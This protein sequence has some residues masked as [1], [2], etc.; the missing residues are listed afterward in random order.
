MDY[1][2]RKIVA[3]E[4]LD[5]IR[6]KVSA[7]AD[8]LGSNKDGTKPKLID[9]TIAVM[10]Y[11]ISLIVAIVELV[12]V[13]IMLLKYLLVFL[14][15]VI[16]IIIIFAF[17]SLIQG[18]I[19]DQLA[20][21]ADRDSQNQEGGSCAQVIT[22]KLQWTPGELSAKGGSLKVYSKNQYKLG[23]LA[24]E[25]FEGTLTGKKLMDI[26]G[27]TLDK[28]VLFAIGLLSTEGIAPNM[29]SMDLFK[30]NSTTRVNKS[31]FG[32]FGIKTSDKLTNYLNS[33]QVTT[34][35][36]KYSP[37]KTPS[38]PAEYPPWGMVMS[39]G[40]QDLKYKA[41]S[42]RASVDTQL[43]KIASQW[44][45]VSNLEEFKGFTKFFLTQA[46]Y[47][48]AEMSEYEGYIN[49]FAGVF[50]V[51][52][53]D[54]SKRSFQN[55]Q[56]IV[57]NGKTAAYNEGG[58]TR[59]IYLGDQDY[60]KVDNYTS[61]SQFPGL[62]KNLTVRLFINGTEI[63]ESLWSYV[64]SN[65]NNKAGFTT[66]V[67]LLKSFGA[68]AGNH[69]SGGGRG[70]RVLNF[71][72]GLNSLFQG[73]RIEGDL[74]K[75]MSLG[76]ETKAE[77]VCTDGNVS[78]TSVGSSGV[79]KATPGKAQMVIDGKPLKTYMDSYYSK[80]N[81]GKV[82]YLR[83][84]ES[85]WGT[86]SYLE[87]ASNAARNSGYVDKIHGVPFYAQ[88]ESL[89]EKW[90][91]YQYTQGGHTFYRSACMIYSYA[92]TA[93]ALLGV[94]INPAEMASVMHANGAL[95]DA[96]VSTS[97]LPSIFT[98]LGLQ[99]KNDK[100]L[101]GLDDTLKKGGVVVIRVKPGK[102]DFTSFE[103][104][105]VIT[106]KEVKDG[107]VMYHMY[108]SSSYKQ[109]STLYTI[110]QIERNMNYAKSNPVFHVWK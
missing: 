68:S 45:I 72:Y 97:K 101:T 35:K 110:A 12:I 87:D 82:T 86:S 67:N 14:I 91:Y 69:G 52:N 53:A 95:S 9:K 23:I 2:D 64:D 61:P 105:Q 21:M 1:K 100:S 85:Y 60:A 32:Y 66:A 89:K 71:H 98:Q 40:H 57:D 42:G 70:A 7:S 88:M 78:Q 74:A 3:K 24:R 59:S 77:V 30:D 38:Y 44:G 46:Q 75:E 22:G 49:W 58:A 34:L 62:S 19:A 5:E 36:S 103:H 80:V 47:H 92:Y 79:Y 11:I 39:I 29:G 20:F 31:G 10:L 25:N 107:K 33:A 96:G 83:G 104:F 15:A 90:G 43:D 8:N 73:Q 56:L 93:S 54:D 37:S 108:T 109:S 84:F 106:G 17:L 18:L 102:E 28:K 94:M 26:G 51:S 76:G 27:L 81:R 6:Q 13:A 50:A 4:R 48:G 65:N 63:K 41:Y 16:L 55:Y 99:S